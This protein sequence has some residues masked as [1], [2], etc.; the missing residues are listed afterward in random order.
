ML[1]VRTPEIAGARLADYS[2]ACQFVV[3]DL[4]S[5]ERRALRESGALP[6]WFF[7]AVERA[8]KARR[9]MV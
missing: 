5:E 3:G 2:F 4:S 1:R 6:T 8:A 7:E 9:A